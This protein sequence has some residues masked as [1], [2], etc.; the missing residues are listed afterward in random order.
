MLNMSQYIYYHALT[1]FMLIV[2]KVFKD[3]AYQEAKTNVHVVDR[4][5]KKKLCK[6]KNDIYF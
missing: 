1:P 4:N 6:N 5:M 2:Y 3:I